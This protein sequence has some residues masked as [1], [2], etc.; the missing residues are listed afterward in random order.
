MRGEFLN[1]ADGRMTL[2]E[3]RAVIA[4]WARRRE[5]SPWPTVAD[6]AEAL[7]L[8]PAEAAAL[9]AE[10]R[11]TRASN[12]TP[13]TRRGAPPCAPFI[14]E[15][16]ARRPAPT[17]VIPVRLTALVLGLTGLFSFALERLLA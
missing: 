9:L 7:D 8:S 2:A 12:D 11:A 10:V 6:V 15:G 3:A 14:Q 5:P 13:R 17:V 1:G 4:L 16:Q